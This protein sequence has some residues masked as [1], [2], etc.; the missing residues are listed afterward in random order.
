MICLVLA[1]GF[2]Q[3]ALIKELKQ[4]EMKVILVD[5]Y[6]N[7]P[8]KEFSDIHYQISTLDIKAVKEVAIKE[9]VDFI[10]TACT[11]QALLTVAQVSEELNLPC[12]ISYET[13]RNVTNKLYMKEKFVNGDI[14][15]A[16]YK[17]ID[18][19]DEEV[20]K[21]FEFPLVVKPVDC[22][23]SKGVKKVYSIGKV[24]E[25]LNEA[26]NFSRTKT[27]IIEEFVDGEEISVDVFV[28]EGKAKVLSMSTSNKAK[29]DNSSFTI[30]QSIYPV[31][32]TSKVK[33]D[34]EVIA[35]K[36]SNEFYLINTP[37]LIQ[38]IVKDDKIHVLEFS[39]RMGGGTKYRF[40]EVI[41]GVNIMHEYVNL[42]LGEKVNITPKNK[43]NYAYMNYCYCKPGVIDRLENFEELKNK[44]IIFD[45][46]QYKVSGMK[47]EK[48]QTSSDRASGYLLIGDTLEEIENKQRV[49]DERLKIISSN[50]EDIIIR[51]IY[52]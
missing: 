12:Y 18:R 34:I 5:Y 49:A 23:S 41:S 43:I 35:Q 40:I 6:S 17:I 22:N 7:P 44:K 13:A 31:N 42:I 4:R 51:G 28:E 27:A 1:G 19:Y 30:M 45:Y 32:I 52:S 16:K 39:A 29:L 37:M 11:D 15:T 2:D 24:E 3:I 14:P 36:I 33:K 47:I 8:A 10:T 46:F 50:N 9:K 26:I 20:V 25:A 38:L 21:Q 48:A